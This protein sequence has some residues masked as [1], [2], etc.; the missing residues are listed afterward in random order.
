[1]DIL[2]PLRGRRT[3]D[4][5][6]L[7]R[8]YG[9]ECFEVRRDAAAD[10]LL[11]LGERLRGAIASRRGA[12]GPMLA[13]SLVLQL[14]T[15]AAPIALSVVIGAV[16]PAGD[17]HL[18][19]LVVVALAAVVAFR[20]LLSWERSRALVYLR[21][22]LDRSLLDQL[23]RHVLRLPIVYFERHGAAQTLQRFESF[24]VLRD[25]VRNEGLRA[26][27]DIPTLLFAAGFVALLDARLL[28]PV[29]IALTLHVAMLALALPRIRDLAA[30]ELEAS[31]GARGQ[32]IEAIAGV[33]TLRVCGEQD[34][35][36]SRWLPWFSRELRASVRQDAA[37]LTILALLEALQLATLVTVIWW[38]AVRVLAGDTTL[39]VL[40]AASGAVGSLLLSVESLTGQLIAFAR[41]GKRIEQVRDTFAE[42]P[43]QLR[44]AMAPPGR[45]RGRIKLE[46]VSFAYEGGGRKVVDD[47]SLEIE[48]G[49]KVALVGASGSGKST[50]GKLLLGFY[51]PD[52]GRVLFD[53][54]D[55]SGLD[56]AALRAQ[57]GV[58]LQDNFL[59]AGTIRE[60]LTI[61]APGSEMKPIIQAANR[62]AIHPDIA[63]LP[64]Q[65]DTLVSEGG[66]SFSGGQR[67]R[68]A[69]ARAL[70]HEP[71]VLL[72]DEATSALDNISQAAVESSL[73]TL[74]CT[75]IVIAHRLS[76][77]VD[78][79][80]I[81]VMEA[82]RIVEH[83]SHHE[84]LAR[85]GRYW[86]LI[87]A[88][89]A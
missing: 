35:A 13:G 9:Q 85:K 61:N 77:V 80:K 68:L 7:S 15:L 60:N 14:A 49:S 10:K 86:E 2:D 16:L 67:Q 45:L 58:V 37:L 30:E 48:P 56:L 38:G 25:L 84:M 29:A 72:L 81:V 8:R 33:A 50:L 65:Y 17:L 89:L 20:G 78:A 76:T 79:D 69:L 43:E 6:E 51:L 41:A 64:M 54:K 46:N 26:A 31:T 52:S 22:H 12:L 59:F 62:A 63:K 18:L 42:P 27:L 23:M 3:I 74:N 19:T 32:L 47:V 82:G 5:E 36:V 39:G 24:R 75:R 66:S 73:A 87:Q 53:G 44:E 71:A 57:I 4:A 40:M 21:F 1:L 70:V 11:G 34:R 28:L 88:Q 83:G 55:L